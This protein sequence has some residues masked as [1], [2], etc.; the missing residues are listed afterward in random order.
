M[1]PCPA[2]YINIIL[3][4]VGLVMGRHARGSDKTAWQAGSRQM[5]I[6]VICQFC[7]FPNK[8]KSQ[9]RR[10]VRNVFHWYSL[11]WATGFPR[12]GCFF[13]NH[14]SLTERFPFFLL[15]SSWGLGCNKKWES[16]EGEKPNWRS[17]ENLCLS[18][19]V[20]DC[21]EMSHIGV[22]QSKDRSLQRGWRG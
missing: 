2:A 10:K 12:D 19:T 21:N 11:K 8:S 14:T 4:V 15:L 17:S 20:V 5:A 3:C 22:F 18:G 9:C 1:D 16:K 7:H 6:S 13:L